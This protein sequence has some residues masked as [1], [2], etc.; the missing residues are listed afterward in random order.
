MRQRG[1]LRLWELA[2]LLWSFSGLLCVGPHPPDL[3][4]FWPF[5]ALLWMLLVMKVM[6]WLASID[7][8]C[9]ALRFE[10]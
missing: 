5:S 1:L 9:T 10:P 8:L 6:I 7:L 4:L 3:H 2:R